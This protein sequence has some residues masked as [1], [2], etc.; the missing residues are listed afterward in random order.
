MILRDVSVGMQ[1]EALWRIHQRQRLDELLVLVN[2][3]ALG[4]LVA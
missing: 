2:R 3:L 4:D 1:A